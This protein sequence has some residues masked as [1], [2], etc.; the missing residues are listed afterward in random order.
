MAKAKR[1]YRRLR[2]MGWV[3]THRVGSHRKMEKDGK[4]L[5]F[6]WHDSADLGPPA[7]AKLA[8]EAGCKPQDLT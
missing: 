3:E 7:L 8:K 1:V 2:S 4:I 5:T 6:S